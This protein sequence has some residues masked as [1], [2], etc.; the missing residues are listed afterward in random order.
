MD[1]YWVGGSG[2]WATA[3]NWSATSGGAGG[4]SV[5]TAADNVFFNSSSSAGSYTVTFSSSPTCANITIGAP[6][7]GTLTLSGFGSSPINIY[8]SWTSTGTGVVCNSAYPTGALGAINFLGTGT[9]TI[10]MGGL[11]LY[12]FNVAYA[13]GGT[14]VHTDDFYNAATTGAGAL[15]FAATSYLTSGTVDVSAG[16]LYKV[17]TFRLSANSNVRTIAFGTN[18]IQVMASN[19]TVVDVSYGTNFSFSGTGGFTCVGSPTSGTR[20]FISWGGFNQSTAVNIAVSGGTDTITLNNTNGACY[21]T[22]DFTGFSG[23]LGYLAATLN[24]FGSFYL[25]PT[26]T[27]TSGTPTRYLFFKSTNAGATYY[28]K[29][30]GKT[31]PYSLTMASS[32]N[33]TLFDDC[34]ANVPGVPFQHS[35]GNLN[36]NDKL[37]TIDYWAGSGGASRGFNFGNTGGIIVTGTNTTVWN[38]G[39]A[40][41]FNMI[42]NSNIHLNNASGTGTRTISVGSSS[43]STQNNYPPFIIDNGTDNITFN[44]Y[45]NGLAFSNN[46]GGNLTNTTF[47]CYGNIT[48]GANVSANYKLGGTIVFLGSNATGIQTNGKPIDHNITIG[49]TNTTTFSSVWTS[50]VTVFTH[51]WG[52]V[53]FT[54][55]NYVFAN[56]KLQGLTNSNSVLDFGN[57][58]ISLVGTNTSANYVSMTISNQD[59]ITTINPPSVYIVPNTVQANNVYRSVAYVGTLYPST[60]YDYYITGNDN[61]KF[62]GMCNNL[63]TIGFSGNFQIGPTTS[64]LGNV[65][66]S[67]IANYTTTAGSLVMG[68]ANKTTIFDS[69]NAN[70]AFTSVFGNVVNGNL[71]LANGINTNGGWYCQSGN[72]TTNNQPIT[73]SIFSAQPYSNLNVDFTTSTINL[74]SNSNGSTFSIGASNVII[75][76]GTSTVRF[77]RDSAANSWKTLG[78][79]GNLQLYNFEYTR[80]NANAAILFSGNGS[81]VTNIA[82][83]SISAIGSNVP[84][85]L[86]IMSPTIV[87]VNSLSISTSET[88]VLTIEGQESKGVLS[89]GTFNFTGVG[90]IQLDWANISN[91]HATPSQTWFG[92]A[93]SINGGDTDGWVFG[94]GTSSNFFLVF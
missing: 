51:N 58:N 57:S 70:L 53:T 4:A 92:G 65:T 49:T 25:S 68:G 45:T 89:F 47:Y 23:T 22:V 43:T 63:N 59:R 19:T 16:Y 87:S 94:Y 10:T 26:M 73:A 81:N 77:T 24:I 69:G 36:L 64:A 30:A 37:L 71:I 39:I 44:G 84:H 55:G 46:F 32:A 76:P 9:Q 83:N 60:A 50:N 17:G 82:F 34:V 62:G 91:N 74:T 52:N 61:V 48:L 56:A 42:G 3:A 31:W 38:Q 28:I 40:G 54:T 20:S 27:L 1:R 12:A 11:T 93:N 75:T 15:A 5:P 13:G 41:A 14:Y 67:P 79:S 80:A 35:S 18:R 72:I 78:T 29:S 33:Y 66:L 88:S 86:K 90:N 7:S 21:G 2:S 8:G 85:R 6:A